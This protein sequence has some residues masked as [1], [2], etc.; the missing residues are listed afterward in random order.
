MM[1]MKLSAEKMLYLSC[2]SDEGQLLGEA[3]QQTPGIAGSQQAAR[4]QGGSE[5]LAAAEIGARSLAR[6]RARLAL[7]RAPGSLAS[8]PPL[9]ICTHQSLMWPHLAVAAASSANHSTMAVLAAPLNE[10][11]MDVSL[12]AAQLVLNSFVVVHRVQVSPE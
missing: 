9:P 1:L 5:G 7:L 3:A 12:S 6:T 2:S 8:R 4:E 11:P 10:F